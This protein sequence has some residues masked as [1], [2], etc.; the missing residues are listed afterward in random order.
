MQAEQELWSTALFNR[1]LAGP[2]DSFLSAIGR[3]AADP[4]HPCH[5]PTVKKPA[6]T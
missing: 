4:V 2:L 6:A 5:M 3:P 1:F